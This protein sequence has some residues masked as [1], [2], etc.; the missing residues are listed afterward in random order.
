MGRGTSDVYIFDYSKGYI[1]FILDYLNGKN[2]VY[3]KNLAF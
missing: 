1:D 3:T 2:P